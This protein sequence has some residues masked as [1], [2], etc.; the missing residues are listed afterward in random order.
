MTTDRS[1]TSPVYDFTFDMNMKLARRDTNNTMVRIDF[2]NVIGY[3]DNL[4]DYPGI[5]SS[6]AS[7]MMRR[8]L[9]PPLIIGRIRRHRP[10]ATATAQA[11]SKAWTRP[12]SLVQLVLASAMCTARTTRKVSALQLKGR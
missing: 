12:S 1:P 11:S 9:R 6:D 5:Q 10:T 4:V 3:W 2:S 8:S 7:N